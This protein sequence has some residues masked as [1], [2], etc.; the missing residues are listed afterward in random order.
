MNDPLND[1]FSDATPFVRQVNKERAP[2]DFAPDQKFIEGCK[3]CNGTG[4]YTQ[5]RFYGQCFA[6]KGQGRFE[7]KTSPEVRAQARQSKV[8]RI[9]R[10]EQDVI[11][12]FK[13]ANQAVWE[14]LVVN[15]NKGSPFATSLIG[16][17]RKFGDLTSGQK[18]AVEKSIARE[19]E[20]AKAHEAAI[21]N[22]P[23]AD[24][25]GVD[26]LKKAFDTAKAKATE[27]GLSIRN[28][29]LTIGS[30]T[31]SPAPTSGKNP[32]ALYVKSSDDKAYLGKIANGKFFAARECSPD[33]EKQ[34][35]SFVADP[36]G[37][38]EAYGQTTGV[39]CICNATLTSEWKNRGI[40]PIC[41]QKF[42]W[43]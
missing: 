16:A 24:T 29:R 19:V 27:K 42:G 6:C 26:R 33:L 41:A 40:G 3:K 4:R 30:V 8:A 13:T 18:A 25:A 39:C 7:Y 36:K 5:G 2:D 21:Q 1:L 11:E 31:I 14:W 28:L 35:L 15:S 17:V 32:G 9:A 20:W 22:A 23:V 10:R 38:A 43:G 34:V 12:A 37:A